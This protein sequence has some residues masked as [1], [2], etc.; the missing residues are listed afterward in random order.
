MTQQKTI[1]FVTP[2]MSGFALNDLNILKSEYKVIQNV[3]DWNKK[4][5]TPFHLI[6]QF[7]FVAFNIIKIN[8][9]IIEFGGYWSL[10]P[11]IFGKL[12][13]KRTIIICHGTD[14]AFL[15]SLNYGTLG[16]KHIKL[17]CK[18]SYNLSDLICPV[19]ES[20]I[21]VENKFHLKNNETN[22]GILSFFPTLKTP[23]EVIHNGL[24]LD[25][26]T[27]DKYSKRKNTFLAVFSEK[28]YR[29][30]GGELIFTM[31]H[32]FKECNFEIV[33]L[34]QPGLLNNTPKNISFLGKLTHEELID[35]YT[36]SEFYFQ[37]SSF[38]GFGLSLC[39]AMLCKC[40]PIGSSVNMIPEIIGEN[41]YILE[42]KN[43]HQ[44]EQI[45]KEALE[46]K[47]KEVVAEKARQSII[48]RF[49]LEKRKMNLLKAIK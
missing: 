14:C 45:I 38:E 34:E 40:I 24:D 3:Y 19:S 2:R 47:N 43:S 23:F 42:E 10:I 49:S 48:N 21:Q 39:E 29:L 5:L 36:Q 37:L 26:W 16:K 32:R 46:L 33:G 8:K 44:L 30:K 22:Q 13:G 9:I 12:F 20:L 25:F 17:I 6:H 18:F 7:F 31:A 28:Q 41:G 4:N 15:P 11:A 35:K 1:L 27:N